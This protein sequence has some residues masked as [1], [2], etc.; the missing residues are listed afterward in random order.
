[1][2]STGTPRSRTAL[3]ILGASAAYTDAG[4]PERITPPRSIRFATSRARAGG[5]ISHQAPAS[6]TRRAMS[7][8][9]CAPRST[10]RMPRGAAG[11]A[12][13]SLV[14]M[15]VVRRFLGDRH[16]VRV[17]LLHPRRGDAQEARLGPQLRDRRRAAVA[18]PGAHAA[19]QLVNERR[20]A[21]L[22]RHD[23]LDAFGDELVRLGDVALTVALLAARLH[24]AERSH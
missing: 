15:E 17:A 9:Y 3:S 1:M 7:C 5:A 21:T 11:A 18:H 19:R 10:I 23:P 2:P 8:A 13:V 24:R 12:R 20:E 14:R 16:V 4:P 6:R 22:V